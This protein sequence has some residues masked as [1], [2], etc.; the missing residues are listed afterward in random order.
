MLYFKF[1]GVSGYSRHDRKCNTQ[2][3]RAIVLFHGRGLAS[4]DPLDVV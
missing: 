2:K 4:M 3:V 1:P